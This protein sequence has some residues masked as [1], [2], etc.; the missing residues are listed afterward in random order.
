MLHDGCLCNKK[1]LV[2]KGKRGER[3][4]CG[5]WE[6]RVRPDVTSFSR[7]AFQVRE[8]GCAWH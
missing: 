5:R 8:F 6:F 2:P 1:P 7:R 3:A 4:G